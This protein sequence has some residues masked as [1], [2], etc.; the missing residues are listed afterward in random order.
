MQSGWRKKKNKVTVFLKTDAEERTDERF[1]AF[2]DEDYHHPEPLILTLIEPPINMVLQFILDPMHLLYL[3]CM[4]RMLEYLLSTSN[5]KAKP[6]STTKN[7]VQRK[8]LV[9]SHTPANLF[10]RKVKLSSSSKK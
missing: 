6:K 1:R 7:K 3:G 8:K 2:A 4:K 10:N 9:P 5:S